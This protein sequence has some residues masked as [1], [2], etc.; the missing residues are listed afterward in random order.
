MWS[1]WSWRTIITGAIIVLGGLVILGV[2]PG[3]IF[4]L[5]LLLACPLLHLL[6]MH[7]GHRG[8]GDEGMGAEKPLSGR[9]G[10]GADVDRQTG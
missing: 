10:E 8:H 9:G 4:L 1:K 5:L 2:S 6:G 7:R 3:Q